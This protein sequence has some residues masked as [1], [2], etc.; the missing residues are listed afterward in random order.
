MA[1]NT[2]GLVGKLKEALASA[3]NLTLWAK[4]RGLFHQNVSAAARG[5]TVPQ[6]SIAKALGYRRVHVQAYL[7]PGEA[8]PL[9]PPGWEEVVPGSATPVDWKPRD[10]TAEPAHRRVGSPEQMARARSLRRQEDP[11]AVAAVQE[12]LADAKAKLR[13]TG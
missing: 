3:P 7:A 5:D 13:K 10:K 6:D 4:E 9:L 11:E 12:A 2:A 1:I 8:L